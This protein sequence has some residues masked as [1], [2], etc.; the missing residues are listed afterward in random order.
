MSL[1]N[2]LSEVLG[3]ASG[4]GGADAPRQHHPFIESV[5]EAERE[6]WGLVIA[7][8]LIDVTLTVHGLQI[9]LRELNPVAVEVIE[10]AGAVGLYLM[11]GGALLVGLC[12]RPLLPSRYTALIPLGLAIPSLFAVIH[13][14]V[15]ILWVLIWM[16]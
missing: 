15:L 1:R 13:N 6:L 2:L 14:S 11:K 12:C 8:M 16:S 3:T 4:A 7:A 5:L 9:G 10:M